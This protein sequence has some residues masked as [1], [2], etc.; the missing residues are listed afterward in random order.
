LLC[1]EDLELELV[2]LDH[3]LEA[4]TKKKVV[5]FCMKKSALRRQNP[6]YAYGELITF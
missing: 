5:S 2:V 3:R 4:T 1:Y 6:G